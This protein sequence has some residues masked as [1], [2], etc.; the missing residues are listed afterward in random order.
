MP[1]HDFSHFGTPA[2]TAGLRD[3]G[4]AH[5]ADAKNGWGGAFAKAG[6]PLKNAAPAERAAAAPD[7]GWAGLL[8]KA[9]KA[10][11]R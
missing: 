2:A 1:K 8:A 7:H 10:L 5:R 6:A 9:G 11:A 3:W 4:A